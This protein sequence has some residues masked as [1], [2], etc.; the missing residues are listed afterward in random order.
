MVAFGDDP[1][2]LPDKHDIFVISRVVAL[3]KLIIAVEQQQMQVSRTHIH[4]VQPRLPENIAVNA[5]L[6]VFHII[7][8][9]FVRMI[10]QPG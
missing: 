8:R 4:K 6:C 3:E 5:V 1:D 7:Y 10:Q 9:V 2:L